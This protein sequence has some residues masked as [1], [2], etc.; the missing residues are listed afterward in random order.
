MTAPDTTKTFPAWLV[1]LGILTAIGPLSIDMY[2]PSFPQ[3][4][5]SLGGAPGSME[6]T[7]SSFF[8]G[9]TLGQL[10]YG[11]VSDRFGRKPPLYFGFALYTLASLGCALASSVPQLVVW[12][13]LQG[14]GG[15]AGIIVP[16]AMVRDR[17]SAR[18]SARAFSMLML[19]MG[20]A[21]ILA[22]ILGGILL[23]HGHWRGI[24]LTLTGFGLLCLAIIRWGLAES[25]D[26][27]HE[28][29]LRLATV[30]GNYAGLLRNRSFLGYTLSGGLG[31]AGMFAYIAGSP[32][33][34]IQLY[35]VTPQQYSWVFAA[36]AGGLI[37]AGQINAQLLKRRSP[38]DLLH[39]TLR[40]P[41][42]AGVVLA[43]LAWTGL[44]SLPWFVAGF[45][46]FVA[47]LGFI[48]PNATA[49]TLATHG[50]MAGTAAAL[51][52]ALQFLLA[53]L[54]GAAVGAFHDGSGRPLALVMACCGCGAWLAHTWLVRRHPEHAGPL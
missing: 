27:R 15:C 51:S 6:F 53:T 13:F 35:G 40:V 37:A 1:M 46:C 33:V 8:I 20:L 24:F 25:H 9:L 50:Q 16:R 10:F 26:T 29:P 14:L 45:F 48:N 4:E 47:S 19:V 11:P 21:P 23:A 12:R 41:F 2:L 38:T 22:P 44:A 18:E 17:T 32:F 30:L 3:V 54:T 36:N 7:L 39:H 42:I 43:L 31:S 5:R 49:S 52:S 34:L 28:P